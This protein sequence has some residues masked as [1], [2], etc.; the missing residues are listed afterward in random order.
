MAVLT[1]AS[2]FVPLFAKTGKF[3]FAP[4]TRSQNYRSN[5]QADRTAL[6]MAF[7][8][9]AQ[10]SNM[11]EGPGPLVKERDACGV[12]FIVN[13][14]SGGTWIPMVIPSFCL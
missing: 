7:D 9:T 6:T 12:G 8:G 5:G 2:A 13:T 14:K 3:V 1:P 11:F 4:S 10:T